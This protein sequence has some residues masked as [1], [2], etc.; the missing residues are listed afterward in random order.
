MNLKDYKIVMG[1]RQ[2]HVETRVRELIKEGWVVLGGIA[3]DPTGYYAQAMGLPAPTILNIL[4]EFDWSTPFV[5]Q[6]LRDKNKELEEIN[7]KI[8]HSGSK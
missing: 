8:I 7:D 2:A 6:Q 5:A 3:I 1:Q 4:T